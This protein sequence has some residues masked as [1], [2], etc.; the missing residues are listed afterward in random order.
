MYVNLSAVIAL[1][2]SL[3]INKKKP[4]KNTNFQIKK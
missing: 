2:K 1:G 4:D 3:K